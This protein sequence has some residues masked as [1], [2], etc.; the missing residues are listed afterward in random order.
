MES[1]ATYFERP[2]TPA[3]IY[4]YDH[5]M[6]QARTVEPPVVIE[7]F[8]QLFIEGTSSNYPLV[9]KALEW[10]VN[11]PFAQSEFKFILNRSYYII[12]NAWCESGRNRVFIPTLIDV[13]LSSP[14]KS[15]A[16][17]K[18]RYLWELVQE[19]AASKQYQALR[20]FA[21]TIRFDSTS[22]ARISDKP[23]SSLETI[24]CRYPYV[25]EYNLLTQDST[26]E[27]RNTIQAMRK[28]AQLQYDLDLS[29]YVAYHRSRAYRSHR[30]T[31]TLG[32]NNVT[33]MPSMNP[34]LL[35]DKH[36]HR[37][38]S[39]Y[40][41]KVDGRNT[42]RDLANCFLT[43]CRWS[44]SYHEFKGDLYEYLMMAM[45]PRFGG[46]RF[47]QKLSD[48]L[49]STLYQYDH[50]P[51]TSAL[52]HETCKS[53]LNFLVVESPQNPDHANFIDLIGNLGSIVTVSI[54]LKII[55][56][57]EQAK[58][59]LERRFAILFNH[60]ADRPKSDVE[61]LVESM[62]TLNVAMSTNFSNLRTLAT[63]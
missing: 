26:V 55:L 62:E 31:S 39:Q 2:I 43:Y 54:L 27:Q 34:T 53:L 56:L 57:C 3:E 59:W 63:T 8:R 12:I 9:V 5:L 44:R 45:G 19:F 21:W 41:G 28:K 13:V 40:I 4:L 16:P 61:W 25:Y 30:S 32:T 10:I 47:G 52:F 46:Q 7:H 22:K 36:L 6:R 48:R 29:R 49:Q 38:L 60:Y 14:V 18:N 11:A 35:S 51:P 1:W 24:L 15:S 50:Q 20:R 42:Q 37:A 23:S 17:L 58:P 33:V